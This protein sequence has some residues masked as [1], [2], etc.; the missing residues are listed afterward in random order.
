MQVGLSVIIEYRK[1]IIFHKF[2]NYLQ[3][4]GQSNN[5]M[6][7]GRYLNLRFAKACGISNN[8]CKAN[9]LCLLYSSTL[10]FDVCTDISCLITFL[11][12]NC[13]RQMTTIQLISFV[14]WEISLTYICARIWWPNEL[15]EQR[16]YSIVDHHPS[17]RRWSRRIHQ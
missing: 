16:S 12:K 11:Y 1:S 2:M 4:F 14:I 3:R 6:L 15:F 5:S 13:R 10:M 9:S 7:F 17:P 8:L